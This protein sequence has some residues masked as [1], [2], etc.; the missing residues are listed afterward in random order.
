MTKNT[1]IILANDKTTKVTALQ[2]NSDEL[3]VR[4]GELEAATGFELKKSGACYDP[5]NICIPLLEDGFVQEAGNDQWLNVSKM[6]TRLEQACV[7]NEDKTVWSL[8]LIPE[9]R[10]AMLASSMAPD[11]E[12]ADIHGDIVRLSDL[13]G[14]KVLI[15]TWATWCGCRFDV[16]IW[17][18]IYEQLN[19]PNFEIICVAED[20]EGPEVA[21]VWFTDAKATYKCIVDPTHKISTLFGWVNVPT[22]AWIDETGKLVRVNESAYAGVHTVPT[23]KKPY[24]FGGTL[25]AEATIDWVKNGLGD[26][27]KQSAEKL[28]ANTRSQSSE[29]LLADAYFKMGLYFEGIADQE[30]AQKYL[31]IA[32]ELA[33]DNWNICRQSWTFKGTDYA[34]QQWRQK[35]KA[36]YVND[37]NWSYY[38]PLDLASK[39]P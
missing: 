37:N 20:S 9:V 2:S 33:P 12:I 36:K 29:D 11:F 32:E 27:L 25:F 7:T 17:Q 13:K 38:E 18:D 28:N 5:L 15:V 23:E 35:T 10:K 26:H 8:G 30:N 14:K 1:K 24:T 34:I 31:T 16:K 4:A 3:W 21:K 19:D 6:A 22:A 39:K